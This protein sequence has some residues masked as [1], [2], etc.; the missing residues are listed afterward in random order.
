MQLFLALKNKVGFLKYRDTRT[1]LIAPSQNHCVCAC[2]HV[3]ALRSSADQ[4]RRR[5]ALGPRTDSVLSS[6][7]SALPPSDPRNLQRGAA[8]APVRH[9]QLSSV[10]SVSRSPVK[11][12]AAPRPPNPLTSAAPRFSLS[13]HEIIMSF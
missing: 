5:S 13:R 9:S 6:C 8:S 3:C 2:V 7:H 11:A 10:Q 1:Y 4:Y 12:S